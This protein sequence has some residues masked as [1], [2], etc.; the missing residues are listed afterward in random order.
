MGRQPRP[1]PAR[2]SEK[3][4]QIRIALDLSQSQM[5]KR[6]G[7]DTKLFASAVSGYEIG[8]REPP[9]PVLLKYARIAGVPMEVLADDDLELPETLPV[10]PTYEE[11]MMKHLRARSHR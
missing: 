8:K 3:L 2:L 10:T 11:W 1:K 4:R 9:I 6:L 5:M 7:L